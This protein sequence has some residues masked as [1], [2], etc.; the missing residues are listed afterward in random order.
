PAREAL[1]LAYG[2]VLARL[3]SGSI[4]ALID[5]PRCSDPAVEAAMNV[6][7]ELF[8]PACF[9]DETLALLHL[10]HMVRLTLAHGITPASAQGLAW[11]G[12]LVGHRDGRHRD[13]YRFACLSRDLVERHGF[14]AFE[15]KALFALE[16]ASVR[17]EPL[18]A[19]V[20]HGRAAFT[21]GA[22]RGDLAV[23]C[24]A[25][26]HIVNDMLVNGDALDDVAQ[27]IAAGLAFVR[28]AG[29]RDVVDELLT[30]QRFVQALRGR[31]AS[32]ATLDGDGF[33]ELAFER[34]LT[35]GRMPTMIFWYWVMKAQARFMAGRFE[36]ARDAL[37]SAGEWLWSSPVHVQY[38]NYHLFSVLTLAALA[39]AGSPLQP[40]GEL[41]Q[42]LAGHLAQLARWSETSAEGF[43]DTLALAQAEL[44]RIEGRELDAERG[45]ERAIAAARRQG[46]VQ[47]EALAHELAARFHAGRGFAIIGQA[48]LAEACYA[49]ERWGATGK[50]RQL[51]QAGAALREEAGRRARAATPSI[52]RLDLATVVKVSQA[53]S[54]EIELDKLVETLMAIALQHAGAERGL[55]LLAREGGLQVEAQ[56]TTRGEQVE[57]LRRGAGLG[58][59]ELPESLLQHAAQ[60]GRSV[61]LDDA[62]APNP[63]QRDPYLARHA[64]RSV[65][66][67]PLMKQARLIGLLYLENNLATHA[68][69]PERSAVLE[70]LASQAAISLENAQLYADLTRENHERRA[71]EQESERV[72]AALQESE[73]RFRRMADAT[74]DVIWITDLEP[75]RVLYAS[76][77]FEHIWGLKV[78]ELYRDAGLWVEAIHPEDR[79][80]IG[81]A[82]GRWVHAGADR[83]W[84]AEFR[85]VQPGGAVRWIHERGVFI[86][87]AQG[88]PQRVSGIST[89]ITARRMA[90]A[91]LRESEQRF[92]LAAAGSNDGIWDWDPASGRTFLSETAQR[93]YGLAPG[94]PVRQRSEW[95][96]LIVLHPADAER[97]RR[98]LEDYLEGRCA[99]YDGEW[100]VQHADGS[101]RWIRVR[102]SSVRDSAGRVTRLAGSVSDIDSQKRAEAALQQTQRLE[103]VGTLAG[104]IAHD[105]NNILSAIL[106]FGEMTLRNTRA[107]SRLRR[108]VECILAA[109][110]RGRSLVERILAFSRSGVGEREPVH[111]EGVVRE[112]LRLL[113]A[114]LPEGIRL[115][116]ALDAGRAATL[117]DSTQ[118]HQVLIN[119]VTNA[120][121]AMPEGGSLR[122]GL[123]CLSLGR[124][125]MATTGAVEAG[126]YLVLSVAD[127]GAGIPAEI[128]DRIFD[129]FFT[130]KEVGTGT[131]LGLSLVHGIVTEI[132]G[133]IDVSTT[134]GAGSTF[135][136]YLPRAGDV[137]DEREV[138]AP[139]LP[140]GAQQQVLVVDDEEPLVEL[141]TETLA[142]LGYL[143]VGFSSSVEALAAFRANPDRFDAIVTD[144]RMPGLSGAALIRAVRELRPKLPV[145]LVSGYLGSAVASRAREAGATSVLG[146]PLSARELA[147][148]LARA[149]QLP[150]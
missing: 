116:T 105:F 149:L 69:T 21:A 139:A 109:G 124:Q 61:L 46:F 81:E 91:A 84:E 7:A 136:V 106:G 133:A 19:A 78:E 35:A 70:L 29:F 40:A 76:P 38:L 97:Q 135:T 103:A 39:P 37:A 17:T 41:A 64:T 20:R 150:R 22:E 30:Q 120:I 18:S 121:Q 54:G 126:E 89:D 79:L 2:E 130:T 82:F 8:A 122:V 50:L 14:V 119:L 72:N 32:L 88:R 23:A 66:C 12:I 45:Y 114:T 51:E 3:G 110:E 11:F 68:F 141:A 93:L 58:Q 80:R 142:G 94:E 75:E 107:G 147:T 134:P 99:A 140:R 117:G 63:F 27:E 143:P 57:V 125:R 67:L 59:V 24:F 100:R 55:L 1:Q 118:V 83:P 85:I 123:E 77:S 128:R 148:S 98:L 90:E 65:L 146:K 62:S 137:A 112:A 43:E 16:I 28:R 4:E 10:C 132:G 6:L 115:E 86:F 53:V 96:A 104:G 42:R 108:D 129:P 131:G 9:T 92:A 47:R 138:Q 56:G 145:L 5:L 44:A 60:R 13:A 71:A 15:A 52:D 127:S 74:P 25:C 48:Y 34:A 101:F 111:V 113:S 31:T 73:G 33:D 102:G 26:H 49:Y 144:E 87:D 95:R 36:Q